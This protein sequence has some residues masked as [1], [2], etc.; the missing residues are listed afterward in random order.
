[1][2]EEVIG[3]LPVTP[4]VIRLSGHAQTND[5]LAIRE[6]A[7][8]LAQQ[9]GA[10][11]VPFEENL[12]Q[13]NQDADNPFVEKTEPSAL[14]MPPPA[15]LLALISVIPT[16]S[17]PTIIVLDAFDLF[18]LHPRQSLLYCLF[19]TVQHSR[20]GANGKGLAV[21]GTTNRVDTINV[22]EKRVKSRFSGRML[23]TACP[24]ELSIWTSIAKKALCA[25]IDVDDSDEWS[26]M[27][28]SAV[29]RV[30]GDEAVKEVL[31]DTFSLTR[32]LHLLSRSLVCSF[33]HS[34]R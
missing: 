34:I 22:L 3:S 33:S 20:V 16:L 12:D 18:A 19:D 15:H 32:N 24:G 23:R 30:L 2:V 1:M 21:V 10:S 31:L 17:R 9:T 5:R 26:S 14:A 28:E 6:I 27:W 25:P 8:Q 13:E 4:N 7:W 29:E 11:L